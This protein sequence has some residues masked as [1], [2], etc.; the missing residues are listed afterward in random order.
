MRILA[1]FAAVFL[2]MRAKC[3]NVSLHPLVWFCKLA[4]YI[5]VCTFSFCATRMPGSIPA[6]SPIP[7]FLVNLPFTSAYILFLSVRP[8]S[9]EES[10]WPSYVHSFSCRRKRIDEEKGGRPKLP[11]LWECPSLLNGRN[12]LRSNK[13]PIFNAMPSILIVRLSRTTSHSRNGAAWEQMQAITDDVMLENYLPISLKYRIKM[14]WT[15]YNT[16]SKPLT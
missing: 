6:P 10:L 15:N 8:E 16:Y 12:S 4:V 11:F 9:R 2:F 7:I 5:G 3:G 14:F 13:T 1:H